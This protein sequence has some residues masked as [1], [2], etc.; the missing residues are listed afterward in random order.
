VH[1]FPEMRGLNL[2]K[3]PES[4]LWWDM[5]KGYRLHDAT[6]RRI[7]HSR[8]VQ[9]NEQVKQDSQS[10]QV[11]NDYQ[12]IVHFSEVPEIEMG[13]DSTQPEESSPP[14]PRRSTKV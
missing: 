4:V 12:L 10:T 8:D 9:F 2:I 14:E 13:N 11:E 5:T 1:M 7:F 3:K 6:Q